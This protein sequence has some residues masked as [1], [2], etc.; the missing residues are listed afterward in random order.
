MAALGCWDGSCEDGA[1]LG[2]DAEE[3]IVGGGKDA[4][5]GCEWSL[6]PCGG[7]GGGRE[8]IDSGNPIVVLEGGGERWWD[9][10]ANV[11]ESKGGLRRKTSGLKVFGEGGAQEGA[12]D[13]DVEW[14]RGGESKHRLGVKNLGQVVSADICPL[15]AFYSLLF[16]RVQNCTCRNEQNPLA[17]IKLEVLLLGHEVDLDLSTG[18]LQISVLHFGVRHFDWIVVFQFVYIRGMKLFGR[19]R[20]DI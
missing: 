16:L 3:A 7:W 19:G 17:L 15:S 18:P 12:V 8:D 14:D 10:G 5:V 13:Q 9:R 1:G 6:G 20:R 11:L 4:W 2:P